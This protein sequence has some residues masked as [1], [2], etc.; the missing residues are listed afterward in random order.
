MRVWPITLLVSTVVSVALWQFGRGWP[1][2]SGPR[3]RSSPQSELQSSVASPLNYSCPIPHCPE[4]SGVPSG[5]FVR[6]KYERGRRSQS[7]V[8]GLWAEDF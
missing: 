7:A 5:T 1:I 6:R 8:A 4:V 2:S 3:I